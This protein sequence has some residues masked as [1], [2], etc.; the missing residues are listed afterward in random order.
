MATRWYDDDSFWEAVAPVLFS[1]ERCGEAARN[2]VEHALALLGAPPGARLLDLCCGPGRHA[3]ALA[4]RGFSVTGVDRTTAYLEDAR[5]RSDQE[6]LSIE[7][8]RADMLDFCRR[9]AFDGVLNLFTSFGYFDSDK[10]ERQVLSNI[11]ESLKPN[12]R[13]IID[14]LSKEVL[15]RKFQ[16]RSWQSTVD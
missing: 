13:L 16:T 4:R 10:E 15:A 5:R 7:F 1:E 11:F 12:G 3:I 6:S 2:E 8:V 9:T 14:I